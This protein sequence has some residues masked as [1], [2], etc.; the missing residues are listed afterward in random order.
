[1]LLAHK[2]SFCII[3][4]IIIFIVDKIEP[5]NCNNVETVDKQKK[6]K[7]NKVI[8]KNNLDNEENLVVVDGLYLV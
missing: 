4:S 5:D 6:S 3:L 7:K 2:L 8:Q 1:M